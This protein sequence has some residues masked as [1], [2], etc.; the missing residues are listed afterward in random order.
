MTRAKVT[1][2]VLVALVVLACSKGVRAPTTPGLEVDSGHCAGCVLNAE[3]GVFTFVARTNADFDSLLA[4]C[5]VERTRNEWLPRRPGAEEVLVYVS[6][7]GSGCEGCLDI[8][9]VHETSRDIVVKVSGGTQGGCEMLVVAGAWALIPQTGKR[10][11]FQFHE[12]ICPD[13]P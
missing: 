1:S 13:G 7:K 9:S 11:T 2:G 3:D 4:N 8:V 6:L 12:V 10:I 5:F